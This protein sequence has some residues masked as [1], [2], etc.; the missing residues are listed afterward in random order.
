[1]IEPRLYRAAFL[2]ALLALIVAAFS[3]EDRPPPLPQALAADVLFQGHA[4]AAGA[5]AIAETYPDRRAGSVGDQTEGRKLAHTFAARG[6][7]TVIDHF[8]G[9]GKPLENVIGRRAG[10][11][12]HQIVVIAPR[13]AG[14]V[15]DAA[16]SAS[17]T[18]ALA[19]MARV[20]QGTPSRK[21]ITLA[22]VDGSTLGELGIHRLLDKLPDRNLIEGVLVMSNMGAPGP[23]VPPLQ[24]WS[25]DSQRVGVGLERTAAT[26]ES[27]EFPRMPHSSGAASQMIRLAFPVGLGPQ[28][29]L[30]AAGDDTV[31]FSG[32]GELPPPKSKSGLDSI[33]A[34]RLGSLGRSVLRTVFAID[35]SPEPPE[36]GPTSY[37]TV[38]GNLLPSWAIALVGLSLILPA[39][40]ASIDAFARARRRREP[41]GRFARWVLAAVLS[42]VAGLVLA[43]LMV[44][45]GIVASPPESPVA[46]DLRPLHG[47]DIV[48]MGVVA[49]AIVVAWALGRRLAV[50]GGKRRLDIAAPGAGCAVALALSCVTL[51]I[52]FI[53]PFAALMLLPA[54]HLWLLAAMARIPERGP[55]PAVL[56][57][58]GL[59]PLV[60]VVLYYMSRL[61]INPLEGLWYVFLLVTSGSVGVAAALF[62]CVFIGVFA[63]LASILVARA[64]R[65]PAARVEEPQRPAVFGP[66]GYAGPGSLGGTESALRR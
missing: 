26:S 47:G 22:S 18:A 36:R 25:N 55:L 62:A 56:V 46:P 44:V 59:L 34:N 14:S 45:V 52:W 17:D 16:S 20:L 31:R 28:G 57:V 21:T 63:C 7:T 1:V 12:R 2:P 50:G 58:V 42:L 40:V 66:G 65:P 13:D 5:K 53:N 49:A 24:A 30:L 33:D 6:F 32:S 60:V 4:A 29:P 23:R 3:L 35:Q 48:A 64:R 41:I 54:L 39:M 43:K 38:A 15:P 51:A 8:S 37:V 61:S 11:S 9:D 27:E 10:A 19:E